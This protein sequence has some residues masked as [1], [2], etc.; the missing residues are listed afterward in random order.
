VS[1]LPANITSSPA[2]RSSPRG[3]TNA[4]ASADARNSTVSPL[5][6]VRST[7]T[8]ASAPSASGAP[9]IVRTACPAPTRRLGI[10]PAPTVSTTASLTGLL[11]DAPARSAARTA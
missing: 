8:I 5:P 4:P 1:A 11:S 7:G 9:V 10:C 3:R 6:R 2:R